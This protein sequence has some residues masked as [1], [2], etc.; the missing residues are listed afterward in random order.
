M[1]AGLGLPRWLS[2]TLRKA[3][4]DA[5]RLLRLFY[6]CS[7]C[8]RAKRC[9]K[10]RFFDPRADMNPCWSSSNGTSHS[11]FPDSWAWEYVCPKSLAE[12]MSFVSGTSTRLVSL[13]KPPTLW[14]APGPPPAKLGMELSHALSL[15]MYPHFALSWPDSERSLRPVSRWTG[16]KHCLSTTVSSRLVQP[17]VLALQNS[18]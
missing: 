15:P 17:Q 1:T 11:A 3:K 6:F 10:S 8:K 18:R 13:S 4:L 14:I 2:D 5:P 12:G 7:A 9:A 16:G